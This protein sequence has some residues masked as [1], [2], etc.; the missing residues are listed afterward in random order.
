MII[1]ARL[2]S[3][4]PLR[5]FPHREQPLRLRDTLQLVLAPILE[6]HA[7]RGAR[8]GS[9]TIGQRFALIRLRPDEAI[10]LIQRPLDVVGLVIQMRRESQDVSSGGNNHLP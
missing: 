10:D 3:T 9:Y 6:R 4:P 8:H 5:R 7:R 2:P 1:P